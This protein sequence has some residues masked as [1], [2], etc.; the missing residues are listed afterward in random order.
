MGTEVYLLDHDTR[1]AATEP[2]RGW[3]L[4]IRP[5][6]VS[7]WGIPVY[8]AVDH[9]RPEPGEALLVR[10]HRDGRV[11]VVARFSLERAPDGDAAPRPAA[12]PGSAGERR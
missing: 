8:V 9:G 7:E 3:D 10:T 1:E 6:V 12:P 11:E 4:R 5:K 2:L